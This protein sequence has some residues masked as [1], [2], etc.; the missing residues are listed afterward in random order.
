MLAGVGKVI[1]EGLF[2]DPRYASFGP[3]MQIIF[4][5]WRTNKQSAVFCAIVETFSKFR[6]ISSL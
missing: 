2:H 3:T 1:Q 5:E 6:Y 4:P